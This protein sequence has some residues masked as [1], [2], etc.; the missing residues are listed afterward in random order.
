[1]TRMLFVLALAGCAP[2]KSPNATRAVAARRNADLLG[3][4]INLS[5][6]SRIS[7]AKRFY[8]PGLGVVKTQPTSCLKCP[9]CR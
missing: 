5:S 3:G 7:S 8:Q 1:M 9:G 6:R 2:T 4:R